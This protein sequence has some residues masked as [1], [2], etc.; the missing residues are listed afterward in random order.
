M[1]SVRRL[2]VPSSTQDVLRKSC[3]SGGIIVRILGE[4]QLK[5]VELYAMDGRLLLHEKDCGESCSITIDG[6]SAG[7]Y[8]LRAI[9]NN[10]MVKTFKFL[11]Q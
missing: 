1:R 6:N 3:A 5:Y 2:I 9:A 11:K 7:I 10:G 8:L 4:G